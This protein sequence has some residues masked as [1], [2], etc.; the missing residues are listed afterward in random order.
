M[1]FDMEVS[2]GYAL[3]KRLID[4]WIGN[5]GM[6]RSFLPIFSA[7]NRGIGEHDRRHCG[8]GDALAGLSI[9]APAEVYSTKNIYYKSAF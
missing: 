5:G 3:M 8:R 9:F 7:C 2:R 4:S 6:E 1:T